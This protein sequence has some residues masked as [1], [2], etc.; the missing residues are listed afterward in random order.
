MDHDDPKI[1]IIMYTGTNSINSD[2]IKHSLVLQM[3]R[4]AFSNTIA[5]LAGTYQKTLNVE[6]IKL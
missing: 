1:G 2:V 5:Q 3:Q 6:N 4:R